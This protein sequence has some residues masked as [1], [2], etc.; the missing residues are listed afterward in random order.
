MAFSKIH[1]KNLAAGARSGLIFK[2]DFETYLAALSYSD[3]G[4]LF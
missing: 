3:H 2:K 1:Q 4:K